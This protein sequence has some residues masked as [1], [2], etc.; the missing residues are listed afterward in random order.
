MLNN[1]SAF[2]SSS[3]CLV[4][5]I[6]GVNPLSDTILD[7]ISCLRLSSVYDCI[8]VDVILGNVGVCIDEN[9][10]GFNLY[11]SLNEEVMPDEEFVPYNKSR[12]VLLN[13]DVVLKGILDVVLK[14]ILDVEPYGTP[15]IELDVELYGVLDD[16]L[17]VELYGALDVELYIELYGAL[18]GAPNIELDVELYGA[19]DIEL[20]GVLYGVLY[21]VLNEEDPE[22][23]GTPEFIIPS[24]SKFIPNTR[25]K[26]INSFL[27]SCITGFDDIK[28]I[29][30]DFISGLLSDGIIEVIPVI[31]DGLLIANI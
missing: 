7:T 20:Y 29:S 10:L 12:G 4:R 8:P 11:G 15:N 28:P 6:P 18:Y 17:D 19:L 30:M 25:L 9:I 23:I 13:K 3:R 26:S 5:S 16:E 24:S 27:G 2:S 31:S 1:N 22:L 14:G 21:D